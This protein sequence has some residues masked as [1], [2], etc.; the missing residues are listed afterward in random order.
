MAYM[1]GFGDLVHITFKYLLEIISPVLECC[2]VI[3]TFNNP[4]SL[5]SK[6]TIFLR[7]W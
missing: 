6:T 3:R 4:Y 7:E 5:V 1:C 2:S